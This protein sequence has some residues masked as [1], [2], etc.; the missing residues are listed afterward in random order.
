MY[1]NYIITILA[2]ALMS[3]GGGDSTSNTNTTS[4]L[5]GI[6]T[7][8]ECKSIDSIW[9][10]SIYEFTN[11]GSILLGIEQFSDANCITSIERNDPTASTVTTFVFEDSG[12]IL[13]EEGIEGGGMKITF[14]TASTE[15]AV[16]AYYTIN[17]NILCFSE[18]FTFEAGLF[19]ISESGES[20]IN[21]SSC[22]E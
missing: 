5:V 15:L 16:S 4:E 17:N 11:T 13:L 9:I 8:Q 20:A 14:T 21:F 6:W 3:C 12:S 2:L 18:A 19:G 22:L 10:K 1:K 7:T